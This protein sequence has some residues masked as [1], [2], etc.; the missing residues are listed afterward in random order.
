[1]SA[2]R[3]QRKEQSNTEVR[4][5]ISDGQRP[6]F[7][8]LYGRYPTLSHHSLISLYPSRHSLKTLPPFLRARCDALETGVGL[9]PHLVYNRT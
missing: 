6:L 2:G 8:D 9:T 1:M 4:P 7:H 3:N 5:R